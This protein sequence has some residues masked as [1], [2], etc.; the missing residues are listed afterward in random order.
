MSIQAQIINLLEELQKEFGLTYLFIAHDLAVVRHISDR[1]AVMY[2]GKIVE[3]APATSSTTTRSIRTRWRCSR[4]SRSP[5]PRREA[6]ARPILWR[7]R[8]EPGEPASAAASTHAA[9]SC[10]RQVPEDEPLLRTLDGHLVACHY[11]EDIKAGRIAPALP[12][13][14]RQRTPPFERITGSS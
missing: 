13:L 1:V 7:R 6:R 14:R 12:R 2:L 10:S 4:R 5:T 3:V 11:A 9:R 8:A